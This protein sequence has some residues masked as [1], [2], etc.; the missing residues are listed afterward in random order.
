MQ[1]DVFKKWA[2]NRS[3]NAFP[4]LF[5]TSKANMLLPERALQT[6]KWKRWKEIAQESTRTIKIEQPQGYRRLMT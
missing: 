6:Q 2:K 1:Q 3:G 4:T 5:R